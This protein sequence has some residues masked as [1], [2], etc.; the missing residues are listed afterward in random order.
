MDRRGWP[1]KK[2]S[3]KT[4]AATIS[5]STSLADSAGNQGKQD[6]SKNVKYVQISA[7][8]YAHMTE[9][10]DQ[11]KTLNEKLSL[12]NEKLSSANSEMTT[13]ENLVKQHAK[14]AEEAVSGWEKA[15]AEALALKHH[16]ESVTL[17]KLTAEDRAS[18]LD[19]A[20]KECMRQVRNVKEESEQKLNEVVFTRT[21]QWDKVRLEL[22]KKIADLDQALLRAS[23]EN[24]ALS[25]SLK[26]HSNMLIVI[27]EEK[28]QADAEIEVLKSN[29]QSCERE[30]SSLKYELHIVSKEL[31]IR[32]EE[33]NMSLRSAE[34]ANKQYLENV[35]KVTKLEAECQRLRG[36]VRKKLP[37]PAALAQ[38]K[39]EVENLGRDYGENRL[40]RSPVMSPSS[41]LAPATEFCLD[42][43]Q[44]C[45]KENE[46]LTAR[47]SAMEEEI[48]MLKEALSKRN[49]ELQALRNAYAKTTSKLRSI[50]AHIHAVNQQKGPVKFSV[51]IPIEGS[52]SQNLS[53]PPSL[54]S[55]SEDGIDDEGSCAESWATTH[56]SELSQFKNKKNVDQ[57]KRAEN[58]NDLELMNDFLEMERLACLSTKSNGDIAFS[59]SV[60]EKTTET[61]DSNAFIDFAKGGD[62]WAAPKPDLDSSATRILSNEESTVEFESDTNPMTLK[63]LQSRISLIFESQAK[64]TNVSKVLDDIK[65]VVQSIQDVGAAE[66]LNSGISSVRDGKL[67]SYIKHTVDHELANAISE[68]HDFVVSLGKE[69]IEMQGRCPDDHRISQKIEEFSVSV[70]NVLC[71]E[72]T[73]DDFILDLSHVLAEASELSFNMPS[74]KGNEV[75]SNCSDCIDKVTLL[76]NKVVHHD[77]PKERFSSDR[78]LIS[79]STSDPEFLREERLGPGFEPKA[80]S[81]KC[82]LEEFEQLKSEK[83]SIAMDLARCSESLEQKKFKL[84]ETEHL[85][86]ETKAQ[87]ASSQKSNSLVETQLKCM[88][89]SYRSLE[90]HACELETECNLLRMKAETLDKKLQ[91]EKCCHQDALVKCKDLEEQIQ[92]AEGCPMCSLS[93]TADVDIKTKQEREITAAAEKLAECQETIFLLGRQLKTMRSPTELVSSPYNEKHK[94]SED[95]MESEPSP[96]GLNPQSIHGSQYVDQA[97]LENISSIINRTGRESPLNTYDAHLSPSD[98]EPSPIS[99]PIS[100][101]RPKHRSTKSSSSSSSEKHAR[102][103]SRFF[104]RGKSYHQDSAL[105]C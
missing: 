64:G 61:A 29:I 4:V 104:A 44:Q 28:S 62:C 26:E 70:N 83:D 53:N 15:E 31:E 21:K 3:E 76:E 42:N 95:F 72:M 41:H 96:S 20:L 92:R 32:N 102:G 80:T 60:E 8:S 10:E 75:E 50:E 46:F 38:M 24:S 105:D 94:R 13:K 19:G 56:I 45:H 59:N 69:A 87:L 40:R 16:L 22:E 18:H 49:S 39:L 6:N 101:K 37:G 93:S 36:L 54:T 103:F 23:A 17:L 51:E 91:E 25:R 82:P 79:H 34:V 65:H 66:T 52:F 73:L 27:R 78:A 90:T 86:T 58:S 5:A 71:C 100:S 47:L 55:M 43:V 57:S 98:T 33:K 88:A 1:W 81:C 12:L 74:D 99:T 11:V 48:K 89:E 7:D 77:R 97:K 63:K 14:V 30:V 85:L 68:I 9:L 84:L 67:C 35:K 2:K